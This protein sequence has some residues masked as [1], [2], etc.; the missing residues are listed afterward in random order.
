M[1]SPWMSVEALFGNVISL[2]PVAEDHRNA[3]EKIA[4]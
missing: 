3:Q 2:Q 4:L 1:A